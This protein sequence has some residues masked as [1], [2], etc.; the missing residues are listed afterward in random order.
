MNPSGIDLLSNHPFKIDL[1]YDGFTLRETVRDQITGAT[2][3]TSYV[4][5]IRSVI[6][7]DTAFVGFTGGTGGASAVQDIQ[8]WTSDF[9]PFVPPPHLLVAGFP[10]SPQAGSVNSFTVA[11]KDF[12][13]NPATATP[14]TVHFTSTDPLAELPDDASFTPADGGTKTFG[15]V[16]KTAGPQSI[17][18]TDTLD[19]RV[20][21]LQSNIVVRPGPTVSFA[22]AA[23]DPNP[24][25]GQTINVTVTAQDAFGNTTPDYNPTVHFDSSDGQAMLPPDTMLTGGTGTFAVTLKTAGTQSITATDFSILGRTTALVA[26]AAASNLTI[27]APD[28]V[29]AGAPFDLIV[30][31]L[32]PFGNVANNPALAYTGTVTFTSTDQRMS[33]FDRFGN[34]LPQDDNGNAIYTFVPDDQGRVGLIA[35]MRSSGPQVVSADDLDNQF[36]GRAFIDV[37]GGSAPTGSGVALLVRPAQFVPT[38]T[39]AAERPFGVVEAAALSK[40]ENL[41]ALFPDP[42]GEIHR[43]A[44]ARSEPGT[45]AS[46]DPLGF[47]LS[48]WNGGLAYGAVVDDLLQARVS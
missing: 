23:D 15:A 31:A 16:L 39:V 48:S 25:A 35:I 27:T 26:A 40:S 5:N 30:T 28:S 42:N 11:A 37:S 24:T 4:V 8:N 7:S 12:L 43:L 41:P 36:G 2:F 45:A 34:P 20:T 10:T 13:G 47:A 22:V 44:L 6:G 33:L 3:N 29:T 17:I 21:E 9:E 32:D 14:I 46:F 18:A 19:T 38:G 1:S